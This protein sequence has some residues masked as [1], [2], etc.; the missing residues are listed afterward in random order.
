MRYFIAMDD[1]GDCWYMV[2]VE[3]HRAWLEWNATECQDDYEAFG[4]K[5]IDGPGSITFTEPEDKNF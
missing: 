3:S 4:A 5:R 1:Y 2:P